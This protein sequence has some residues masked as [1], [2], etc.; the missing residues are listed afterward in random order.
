MEGMKKIRSHYEIDYVLHTQDQI[1]H[2]LEKER[3]Y[4]LNVP[5]FDTPDS[6]GLGDIISSSFACAIVK[7]KDSIWAFCFAVG[8][9]IAALQTN[10]IGVKKIPSKSAI[11]EN[12]SY[13]YNTMNFEII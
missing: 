10:E 6:T 4:W 8:A 5:K 7:E 1:I 11:E 13:Y 12:A 3:H 2:L 9:L